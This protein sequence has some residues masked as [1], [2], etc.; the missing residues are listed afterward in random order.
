M[1]DLENE[2]MCI[3]DTLTILKTK[4]DLSL[5]DIKTILYLQDRIIE[6]LLITEYKKVG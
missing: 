5:E 6:L 3:Y 4:V 2:V 1:S